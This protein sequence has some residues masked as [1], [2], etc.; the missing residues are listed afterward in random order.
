M[1]SSPR[2]S[3][4]VDALDVALR[5]TLNLQR[6]TSLDEFVAPGGAA[7][8]LREPALRIASHFDVDP[9][10]LVFDPLLGSLGI[11][12]LVLPA[13][14]VKLEDVR[15]LV[16][17]HIDTATYTRHLMVRD[18]RLGDRKALSVELVL[19]S[20]DE[21]PEERRLLADL[22]MALRQLL[23]D[24]DSLFHIGVGVLCYGGGDDPFKGRI[25]RAFPWL[26]RAT[27]EWLDSPEARISGSPGHP[28]SHEASRPESK[29]VAQ[30]PIR[31]APADKGTVQNASDNAP[32]RLHSII[33][34]NYR[35][36]GRREL[37]L[38]DAR[39]HLVHGPNGSGKSSIVEALELVSTGKIERL[40]LAD[41]TRYD[42]VIRNRSNKEEDAKIA[43]GWVNT[44]GTTEV[45]APKLVTAEGVAQ[46]LNTTLETNH[47]YKI[48]ASSFRL[49]QALMDRLIGKSPHA[50]AK[51]FMRA[52]FPEATESLD[53]Y[54]RAEVELKPLIAPLRALHQKLVDAQKA[55][56]AHKD[57]RGVATRSGFQ[58]GDFPDLL[59]RW[60]EATAIADLLQ[61]ERTIRETLQGITTA[62]WNS[63]DYRVTKW[64]KELGENTDLTSVE[65]YAREAGAEV[66]D[67]QQRLATL[68]PAP[69]G[70]GSPEARQPVTADQAGPL[71]SV[72]RWI[73][74][75]DTIK[76]YGAFGEKLARVINGGDAPT[77]GT[78]IIGSDKWTDAPIQQLNALISACTSI[79]GDKDPAPWPGLVPSQDYDKAANARR[80]VLAASRSLSEQFVDKL[81][82]KSSRTGEFD[83]SLIAA[84]N[85]LMAL[86][87]P[88]RWSYED[89]N[90]PTPELKDGAVGVNIEL[91]ADEKPVRAELHL[92][93][94]ELNLF[95]VAM[96]V[97]CASRVPKPLNLLLF[98]DPLQNMDELTSTAL[99]RGLARVVRLW[100]SRGRTEELLLLFH[101]QED[102]ERF[103]AEIAAAT[104]R[105][106]WLSPSP[107]STE[108]PLTAENTAGDVI[109]VQ[110]LK[111]MLEM[112]PPKRR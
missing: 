73:I 97:L 4:I 84:L 30:D 81:R 80:A 21:T 111:G 52:F 88:S 8:Y 94:A 43:L 67:L 96:F 76:N 23:R 100:I 90:L 25:R 6:K 83:G 38:S 58:T 11:V 39:V 105:L 102:L 86:F 45:D 33:L 14:P 78:I 19:L 40:R 75:E 64:I 74:D 15:A 18:R 59:N 72:S 2:A 87:T 95:T 62:G 46:P 51:E 28:P 35:L 66:D 44:T 1:I 56:D 7:R 98:D 20:A 63:N 93:T 49:D 71:N 68:A 24:A 48:D 16:Q 31:D 5:A 3:N 41:E 92:N 60:L 47:K 34:D 69:A 65:T 104:Y 55:L 10:F 112:R 61:R 108:K 57:W 32:R 77:Y 79:E 54:A 53:Q 82:P 107:L 109:E 27:R 70:A 89:I 12:G 9:V 50:R 22:G 13:V 103:S 99:A 101:G 37:V 36:P 26:L 106:P 29:E 85:E 42:L 17:R 110:S 91:G